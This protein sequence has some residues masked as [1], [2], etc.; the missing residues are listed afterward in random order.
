MDNVHGTKRWSATS[1]VGKGAPEDLHLQKQHGNTVGLL[2]TA[3][4]ML[5]QVTKAKACPESLESRTLAEQLVEQ[6]AEHASSMAQ[7]R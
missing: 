2:P 6:W 7:D 1:Y 3:L 5:R 4:A